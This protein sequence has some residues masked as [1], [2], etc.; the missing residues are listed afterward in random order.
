MNLVAV[1]IRQ[2]LCK[3]LKVKNVNPLPGLC[4]GVFYFTDFKFIFIIK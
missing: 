1:M 4:E 3:F 2:D